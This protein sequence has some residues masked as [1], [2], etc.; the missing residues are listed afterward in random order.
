VAAT[1]VMIDS[2]EID[3]W[4]ENNVQALV[5]DIPGQPGMGL[6]GLNYLQRFKMNLNNDSG[7]LLLTPK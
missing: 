6:L 1:Q 7:T 4:V 5:I 3:G 2:L